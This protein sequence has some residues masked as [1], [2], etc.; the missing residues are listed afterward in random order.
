[1]LAA[2]LLGA[3]AQRGAVH[4]RRVLVAVRGLRRGGGRVLRRMRREERAEPRRGET[5]GAQ[6]ARR[7][8]APRRDGR[9]RGVSS[10]GGDGREPRGGALNRLRRARASVRAR[11]AGSIDRL[12]GI[13]RRVV[14]GNG[15]L[16]T[17]SRRRK[18]AKRVRRGRVAQVPVLVFP[19]EPF[20]PTQVPG[21]VV[22]RRAAGAV[23]GGTR[24]DFVRFDFFERREPGRARAA[25][26]GRR[27]RVRL[28]GGVRGAGRG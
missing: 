3:R 22:R 2:P 15:E 5:R 25:G 21:R 16:S 13:E 18:R 4:V 12:S 26:R 19:A 14:P 9:G 17:L 24:R 11:I 28:R 1:M 20:V 23:R 8:R 10:D 6:T 7:A 27:A